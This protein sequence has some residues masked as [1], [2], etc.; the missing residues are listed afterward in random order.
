MV[1]RE[2]EWKLSHWQELRTYHPPLSHCP[3]S[4]SSVADRSSS[5]NRT[6]RLIC[7]IEYDERR[8]VCTETPPNVSGPFSLMWPIH[9]IS[10]LHSSF[11]STGNELDYACS[12]HLHLTPLEVRRIVEWLPVTRA[13]WRHT[14]RGSADCGPSLAI[15]NVLVSMRR[16]IVWR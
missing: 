13:H 3:F 5:S 7:H 4:I 1:W 2:N 11:F 12:L 10:H 8:F 6:S 14:Q 15:I 9:L 16:R